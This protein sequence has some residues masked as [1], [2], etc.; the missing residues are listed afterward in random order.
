MVLLYG[1]IRRTCHSGIKSS[2]EFIDFSF[3][4]TDRETEFVT[5]KIHQSLIVSIE[6][7]NLIGIQSPAIQ[8]FSSKESSESR[9]HTSNQMFGHEPTKPVLDID[10]AFLEGAGFFRLPALDNLDYRSAGILP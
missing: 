5:E 3:G 7:A 8:Y 4:A 10:G 9:R 1:T 2:A 6:K